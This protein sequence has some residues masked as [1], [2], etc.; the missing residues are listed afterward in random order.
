M[1]EMTAHA[2]VE[3]QYFVA[4]LQDGQANSGIGLGATMRLHIG[5]FAVKYFFQPVD[6]Q[7]FG[8]I[9]DFTTAIISSA[10]I[11]F[12]IFIGHYIAH[13]LHDLQGSEIFRGDQFNAMTLA[14]KFF[15]NEVENDLVS[16]HGAKIGQL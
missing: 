2:Q 14:F 12:G 9:H 6:G 16:L 3:P 11:A 8:L 15:L 13:G 1:C 10:G 4:R 7:L 5:I